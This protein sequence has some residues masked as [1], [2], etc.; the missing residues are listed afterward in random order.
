M[1]DTRGHDPRAGGVELRMDDLAFVTGERCEPFSARHIP[2][3][4]RAVTLRRRHESRS[5]GTERAR[6]HAARIERYAEL[7][8]RRIPQPG[9]PIHAPGEHAGAVGAE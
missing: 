6:Y 8:R 4:R 2:D 7:V 9:G 1:V 5:I 3:R